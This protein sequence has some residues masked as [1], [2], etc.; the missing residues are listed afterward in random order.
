MRNA[1]MLIL[2]KINRHR[3]KVLN[4]K[5]MEIFM[6]TRLWYKIQIIVIGPEI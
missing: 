5:K 2:I 3:S 4:I 6:V 1:N